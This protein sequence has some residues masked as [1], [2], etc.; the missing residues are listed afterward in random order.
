MIEDPSPQ[1]RVPTYVSDSW[2]IAL[3][4]ERTYPP[5]KYPALF[6]HNSIALQQAM[7]I[8][9]SRTVHQHLRGLAISLIGL[10]HVLDDRGH[11]HYMQTREESFG[12][13][14][15][16]LLEESKVVWS[17][18]TRGAWKTIGEMLDANGPMEQAGL[19]VMGKEM[20]YSDF[21]IAGLILW[22]QRAEGPEGQHY[23]ELL[24]WDGGRWGLIWNE[25]EKLE[26]KSTE[27]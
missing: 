12:K 10:E 24:E 17:S 21:V 22:L 18:D 4:L 3:Y 6:P 1:G 23:K 16:Q 9:L 13:P 7:I 2:A 25:I 11:D 27:V 19:F 20:S 8:Q 5:P 26:T 14:L 15:T